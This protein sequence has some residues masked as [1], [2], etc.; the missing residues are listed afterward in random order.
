VVSRYSSARQSAPF[1][2]GFERQEHTPG[3]AE[4]TLI[5]V[6]AI[7]IILNAI[8]SP[9]KRRWLLCSLETLFGQSWTV[10]FIFE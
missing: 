5:E 6:H 1:T 3:T 10:L 8:G 2:A 4:L 9:D 7:V